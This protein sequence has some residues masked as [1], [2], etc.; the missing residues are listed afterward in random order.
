MST[1]VGDIYL[2]LK[3]NAKE[4]PAALNRIAAATRNTT[5][6][7]EQSF[8]KTAVGKFAQ[9]LRTSSAEFDALGRAAA[10]AKTKVESLI[11]EQA[12]QR[13]EFTNAKEYKE[14]EANIAQAKTQLDGLIEQQIEA[15]EMP[16]PYKPMIDALE[17][18]ID[19]A[20][21]KLEQM[22]ADLRAMGESGATAKQKEAFEATAAAI[23][24]AEEELRYYNAR[25]SELAPA[26]KI[27]GRFETIA[28][29]GRRA[30]KG[31]SKAAETARKTLGK[32]PFLQKIVNDGFKGITKNANKMKRGLAMGTGVRGLVRLGLA[33][34]TAL[35]AIRMLRQGMENLVAYDNATASS[36]NTLKSSLLYLK[37]ALA[38]AFA[39]ILNVIAPILSAFIDKLARAA[40]L[41]A[42]FMAALT[43]K[44]AVVVAKKTS[45]ALGGVADSAGGVGKSAKSANK[46][47]KK[48]Q[49]TLMGFDKINKLDEKDKKSKGAGAGSGSGGAGGAGASGMFETV[50]VSKGMK[51]LAEKIKQAWRKGDFTQ[52][53]AIV[54]EKLNS[55][56]AKIP[57]EKIQATTRKIA[58]SVATFINGF[59]GKAN[60]KLIARTISNG[61]ATAIDMLGEFLT[62]I[63]WRTVGKAIVNFIA[64]INWKALFKAS[65]KL[66]GGIVGGIAGVF[67]GIASEVGK[68]I[69]KHFKKSIRDAGGNIA[70]GLLLGIARGVKNI[71]S[72][73]KNNIFKPFITA[74]KKA[75][76]IAS[77]S[78]VMAQYGGYIVEGLLNGIK[79]G[80]KTVWEK[81]TELPD[82]LGD[83]TASVTLNLVD[84]FSGAWDKVKDAWNGIKTRTATTTT[85]L[86]DYFKAAWN[87]VSGV[88]NGIKNRTRSTTT[89]LIDKF[90]HAWNKVKGAWNGIKS[91]AATLTIKLKAVISG[92]YNAAAKKINGLIA[93]LPKA[94]RPS[95][96]LPYLAQGGWVKKNTPQLAVVGDNRH[97]SEIVAPD[98]KLAAMARQAANEASG[99]A[100][101]AQIIALLAQLL[102]AVSN[103][104]TNVY[105]D[106]KDITRNTIKNINQQTRTTGKSPIL[107]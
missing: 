98:S 96:K 16:M 30:F 14:L 90:S 104:D 60:W 72:F 105:L 65:A 38:T 59:V 58:R 36:I 93:K 76:G 12:K 24:T 101:N 11:A 92:A 78:K 29:A 28:N 41:V 64:G 81:L 63:K 56:L 99:G 83:F 80:L 35:Y 102:A 25:L 51:R 27:R 9:G 47:A 23:R 8:A 46:E 69:K 94:I 32:I 67:A 15:A 68:K 7:I 42:H 3:L 21:L 62:T 54:A 53:G 82:A 22:Q 52:I 44:S 13:G 88:W 10:Q 33:G 19:A 31:I 75:F 100:G 43:G 6:K 91:K 79:D 2:N 1:G 45:S 40:T 5:A 61:I 37:N 48:L 77:P 4:L 70:K 55:A 39:P 87:K 95:W 66:A 74:F 73:I 97:E 89:K 84:N 106:G 103:L 86:V 57:W 49:R 18:Q 107:V 20:R 26:Q 85:K 50:K 71:G 34:A 17:E